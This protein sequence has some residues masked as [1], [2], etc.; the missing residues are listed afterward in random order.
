MAGSLLAG[1]GRAVITPPVGVD[2]MGTS[3]RSR[4]SNGVHQDLHVTCL[5]LSIEDEALA[6]LDCDLLAIPT[7][8]AD[9]FRDRVGVI[10]GQSADHVLLA[11]THTHNGPVTSPHMP[12][13]GGD[14]TRLRDV[15]TA[16]VTGLGYQIESAVSQA[17]SRLRPARLVA[18]KGILDIIVNRR[19]QLEDGQVVIGRN[20]HGPRDPE[21]GVL[22][23]DAEEGTPLA[24]IVNFATHPGIGPGCLLIS[25]DVAGSAR[26]TLENLVGAPALYFTGAAANVMLLR[27]LQREPNGAE[28]V[29]RQIGCEAAAVFLGLNSRPTETQWTFVQSVSRLKVYEEVPTQRPPITHFRVATRQLDLNLQPLPSP[30]DAEATLRAK[31]ARVWQLQGEGVGQDEL[32]PAIYQEIWARKL[33]E[34]L[35]AGATPQK[36]RAEIQA[37]RLDDIAVVAVPG[38]PFV[39]IGLAV[40]AHSPFKHTFFIGYANGTIGYIPTREAYPLGGYEVVDAFKGYGFPSAL[41]PGAAELI[42]EACLDLL[43]QLTHLEGTTLKPG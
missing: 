26:Q 32:N 22:R 10:I 5:V 18:G 29:G 3:R 2:L 12:K 34:G 8:T 21:L 16:Y 20:W 27:T 15:E 28:I 43:H 25:P 33:V 35:R 36:V 6:L 24:A 19:E 13:I 23:V 11:C 17:V 37:I 39:E 14:Q 9:E 38:E 42:I 7:L 31:Q 40:K 1:V 30:A 41:A 4:P